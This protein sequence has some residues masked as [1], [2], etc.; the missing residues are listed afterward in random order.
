MSQIA[1]HE[2]ARAQR[3]PMSDEKQEQSRSRNPTAIAAAAVAVPAP[4]RQS[5]QPL[6]SPISASELRD[7]DNLSQHESKGMT[8]EEHRADVD[9]KLV[10]GRPG[11]LALR[12]EDDSPPLGE[13][14]RELEERVRN[15]SIRFE[16]EEQY[17]VPLNRNEIVAAYRKYAHGSSDTPFTEINLVDVLRNMVFHNGIDEK[18]NKMVHAVS[19]H[20]HQF[21]SVQKGQTM[22]MFWG[23]IKDSRVDTAYF[24]IDRGLVNINHLSDNEFHVG[25]PLLFELCK[26]YVDNVVL[27]SLIEK[28]AS[29]ATLS[30]TIPDSDQMA[31]IQRDIVFSNTT[32]SHWKGPDPNFPGRGSFETLDLFETLLVNRHHMTAVYLLESYNARCAANHRVRPDILYNPLRNLKVYE[33]NRKLASKY[34]KWTWKITEDV[35]REWAMS[36][37][38]KPSMTV[39]NCRLIKIL[40]EGKYGQVWRAIDLSAGADDRIVAIKVERVLVDGYINESTINKEVAVYEKLSGAD[41]KRFPVVYRYQFGDIAHSMTMELVG[42]SMD[43]MRKRNRFFNL[44]TCVHICEEVMRGLQVMHRAQYAH[45]DIW[46]RNV[47]ISREDPSRVMLIDM[48]LTESMPK[49]TASGRPG[50]PYYEDVLNAVQMAHSLHT[51]QDGHPWSMMY[52]V[53]FPAAIG[54]VDEK[55]AAKYNQ[56]AYYSCASAHISLRDFI[57]QDDVP[58]AFKNI[59]LVIIDVIHDSANFAPTRRVINQFHFAPLMELLERIKNSIPD[60]ERVL[61]WVSDP[62][63]LN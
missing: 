4:P 47:A 40:G 27:A 22:Q 46:T 3:V 59:Y 1:R 55:T 38:L 10:R 15:Y 33:D 36:L 53:P 31:F 26:P 62:E 57:E 37:G 30:F 20:Q 58:P 49:F 51:G 23:L 9:Q 45:C 12:L 19:I 25:V 44:Y 29:L 2:F 16:T 24:M 13:Q 42:R 52:N 39:D 50:N 48:G 41:Q 14:L 7:W 60:R 18:V 32:G 54:A 21:T 61:Q 11:R 43:F 28:H 6:L 56:M 35:N 5:S 63:I 34:Q 8:D 17:T